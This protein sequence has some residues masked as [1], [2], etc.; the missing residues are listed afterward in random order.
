MEEAFGRA[1]NKAYKNN[2]IKGVIVTQNMPNIT[3]QQYDDDTIFPGESS[4]KEA[5]NYKS[6]I[7]GFMKASRQKLNEAKSKIFFLNIEANIKNQNFQI[8]GYK[9]GSFPC[10]YLGIDLDKSSK[11]SK[12]WHNTMD[13]ME[14]KIGNWKDRWLTKAGKSIKIRSV[15]LEILTY[16]L[17]CLP[18]PKYLLHKFEAKL[19]DFLWN[20]YE[21]TKKLALVKWDKFCKPKEHGGLGIKNLAWKMKR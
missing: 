15:L 7:D 12:V 3:H 19:R 21:E 2:N 14:V 9:K 5:I 1:I 6:I 16:P 10:K 20:D 17:S 11:S 4:Q 13:K 18:L 8:M